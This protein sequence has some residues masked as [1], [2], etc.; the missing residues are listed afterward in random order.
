LEEADG[1]FLR[2]ALPFGPFLALAAIEY[3]FLGE[4]LLRWLTAG[5]YP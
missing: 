3:M 5:V 4:G 2:L 1:D